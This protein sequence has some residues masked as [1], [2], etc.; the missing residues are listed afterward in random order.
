MQAT[1]GDASQLKPNECKVLGIKWNSSADNLIFTF[2]RLVLMGKELPPTKRN[3]LKAVASLFDPIGFISPAAVQLQIL[4]QEACLL[5]LEWHMSF[6]ESLT[7]VYLV[8][9]K[10]LENA[11]SITLPRCYFDV[12]QGDMEQYSLHGFCDA[13][14]KAYCA[15]I[16]LVQKTD[17]GYQSNSV[18]SKSRVVPLKKLTVAAL[19]NLNRDY[20]K[21]RVGTRTASR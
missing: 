1:V 17:V 12:A 8:L 15:V 21:L 11:L 6:P 3:L 19:S 10:D 4:L 13:S 5:N 2:E 7:N 16:Y 9:L 20:I 18:A 14:N